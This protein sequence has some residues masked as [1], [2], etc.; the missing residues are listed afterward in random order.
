MINKIP[1]EKATKEFNS[2]EKKLHKKLM[3]IRN[4]AIAHSVFD[5]K[6]TGS[7]IRGIALVLRSKPYNIREE[8]IDI[9][10]MKDLSKKMMTICEDIICK[11]QRKLRL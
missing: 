1:L 2:E 10:E 6:P 4:Q 8:P 5:K 3:T 11:E 7:T 9:E